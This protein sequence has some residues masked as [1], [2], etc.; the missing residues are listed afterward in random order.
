[1][2]NLYVPLIGRVLL[3][4]IFLKSGID[5]LLDP[6]AT[7]GY[8]SSKGIPFANILILPTIVVLLL[9]GLSVLLGYRAKLGAWLLIGFLIPATL[10]FHTRFPEEEIAFFKNLGL[11][12]GLLMIATFGSGKLSL[13]N[14]SFSPSRRQRNNWDSNHFPLTSPWDD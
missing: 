12:G 7:A 8:M 4:A 14:L 11:I 2:M 10:I 1:M 6:G 3:S 5:K 13:D 9:G